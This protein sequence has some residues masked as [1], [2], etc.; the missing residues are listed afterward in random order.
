MTPPGFLYYNGNGQVRQQWQMNIIREQGD[1]ARTY[2]F[3][4]G[5]LSSVMMGKDTTD[6]YF[7]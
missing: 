1:Y 3:T 7:L 6:W 4:N 2:N 5:D